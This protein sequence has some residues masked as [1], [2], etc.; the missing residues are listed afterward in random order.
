MD[1]TIYLGSYD[2]GYCFFLTGPN[3]KHRIANKWYRLPVS[4]WQ[5]NCI[6]MLIVINQWPKE[7]LKRDFFCRVMLDFRINDSGLENRFSDISPTTG[8]ASSETKLSL[9]QIG[10]ENHS[11]SEDASHYCNKTSGNLLSKSW[12]LNPEA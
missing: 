3:S 6:L 4:S 5:N 2:M 8:L 1:T 9:N 7:C 10:I 11:A 12:S